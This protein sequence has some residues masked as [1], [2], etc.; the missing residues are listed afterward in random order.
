L[1][2]KMA[3]EQLI[4][5]VKERIDQGEVVC[6]VYESCGFW[7]HLA[8]TTHCRRS[9]FVCDY[10]DAI[11]LGAQKEERPDGC[12]GVVCAS[13]ALSGWSKLRAAPDSHSVS[14]GAITTRAGAAAGVLEKR[15]APAGKSRASAAHRA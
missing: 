14:L 15:G 1:A 5:W 7:L 4:E 2:A 12:A 9:A 8:R 3:R 10:T 6:T 11:K 13:V